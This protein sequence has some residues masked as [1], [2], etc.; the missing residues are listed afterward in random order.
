MIE[1]EEDDDWWKRGRSPPDY[2]LDDDDAED[3][4]D[5]PAVISCP[6]C[7]EEAFDDAEQCPGCGTWF[8]RDRR[9]LTDRPSGFVVLG[10]VGV[11][12]AIVTWIAWVR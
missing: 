9:A 10:F 4:R 3:C 2:E 8:T 12:L 1:P 11:V 6:D 5:E 7:G